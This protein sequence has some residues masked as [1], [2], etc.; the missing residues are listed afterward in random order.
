MSRYY[1]LDVKSIPKFV[2][3]RKFYSNFF[4][5]TPEVAQEIIDAHMYGYQRSVSKLRVNQFSEAMKA[6]TFAPVSTVTF[7]V[8]NGTFSC[9]DGQHTLKALIKSETTLTLP[10][11]VFQEEQSKLYSKIDKGRSR[12]LGDTL[13]AYNFEEVMSLSRTVTRNVAVAVRVIAADYKFSSMYT[14]MVSEEAIME[15][16]QDYMIEAHRCFEVLKGLN[17]STLKNRVPLSVF[18]TLYKELP[19]EGERVRVDEFIYGCATDDGLSKGDPRKLMYTLYSTHG[20]YGGL[21]R[22]RMSV[23]EELGSLL[24]AWKGYY[25]TAHILNKFSDARIANQLKASPNL[26]GTDITFSADIHV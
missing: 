20:R 6:G 11:M 2:A 14:N 15:L 21:T 25:A 5:F 9:V 13:K 17:I 4:T 1:N 12:S 8:D 26:A 18:L 10:V 22:K 7:A 19:T 3:S 16:M 23:A 24:L